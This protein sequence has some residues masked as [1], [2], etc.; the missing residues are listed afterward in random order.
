M[1]I[2]GTNGDD[3]IRD[4]RSSVNQFEVIKGFAGNDFIHGLLGPDLI[5]GGPGNDTIYGGQGRD[6][7]AGEAGDDDLDGGSEI[8][9]LLFR[10]NE[11]SYRIDLSNTQRQNTGQGRDLIVGF[12]MVQSVGA[13]NFWIRGS[14]HVTETLQGGNGNDTLISGG[15]LDFLSGGAGNDLLI[16]RGNYSIFPGLINGGAGVDTLQGDNG[17]NTLEAHYDQSIEV[18]D[19]AGGN[20]RIFGSQAGQILRGGAG[21]DTL[22]AG[23]ANQILEGGAGF[24]TIEIIGRCNL[25]LT[26]PQT[27]DG[28]S[29]IVLRG[30]EA[31]VALAGWDDHITG[32]HHANRLASYFGD[33]TLFGGGG[34]DTLDGGGNEDLLYGQLGDDLL[35]G[36]AGADRLFGGAGNDTLIGGAGADTLS[37][38]QG[39]DVFVFATGTTSKG[40]NRDRI[41]DFQ[42]GIDDLDLRGIDA[43]TGTAGNQ[44]L[45]FSGFAARAH[46]VWQA[47]IGDT[48]L[49]RGDTNGDAVMDFEI[50][51]NGASRLGIGDFLL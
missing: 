16:L 7:I 29:G 12:E 6:T 40:S 27:I 8:D 50:E 44:A 20:D 19:G 35:L 30:I 17:A 46:S 15:D 36:Q 39:A 43:D 23:G 11:G 2:N 18:I 24:D 47:Q 9:T 13:A 42:R 32:N 48:T 26:G 33:D 21:N 4:T 28:Y 22:I 5:Y 49:L 3:V 34:N 10:A 14:A 51:I 31:V 45:Q 38:G 37:G 1:P 41:T 25:A